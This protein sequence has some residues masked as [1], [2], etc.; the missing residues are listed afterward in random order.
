MVR[1][2]FTWHAGEAPVAIKK[3]KGIIE[4]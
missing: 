2:R 3:R 1:P 4:L